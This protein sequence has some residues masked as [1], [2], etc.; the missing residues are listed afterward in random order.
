MY[1]NF[2]PLVA[3]STLHVR[4]SAI[5]QQAISEC[6]AEVGLF[7]APAVEVP[8]MHLS[9][10]PRFTTTLVNSVT[11][12][13]IRTGDCCK[14]RTNCD[15]PRRLSR[16]ASPVH[17][18]Q[19]LIT[20]TSILSFL[21]RWLPFST[22]SAKAAFELPEGAKWWSDET[23]AVVTGGEYAGILSVCSVQ[24]TMGNPFAANKGIGY[25]IAKLLASQGLLTVVAARNGK[26]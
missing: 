15:L 5:T 7:K 25:G 13:S 18:R 23:V 4:Q 11:A 21:P 10:L 8:C 9:S 20:S 1:A 12:T 19:V 2:Q 6:I 16:P 24:A 26:M 17:R 3:Q 22:M 14:Q